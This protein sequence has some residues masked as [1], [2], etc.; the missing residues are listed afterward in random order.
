MKK[1]NPLF[2]IILIS[3]LISFYQ[4]SLVGQKFNKYGINYNFAQTF[5]WGLTAQQWVEDTKISL[6]NFS[7]KDIQKDYSSPV[8]PPVLILAKKIEQPIVLDKINLNSVESVDVVTP[9]LPEVASPTIVDSKCKEKCTILTIGDSIMGDVYY[10]LN[11]Q[12]KKYHPDWKIVN[13]HKVSSGLSNSTY[14]NWPKVTQKLVNEVKPDYVIIL[15]GMNDAQAITDESKGIQFNTQEWTRVYKERTQSMF[16]IMNSK[17][18][19]IWIELPNV[20]ADSFD[21]R[22]K[23]VREIH[24]SITQNSYLSVQEIIGDNHSVNFN[25]FRQADG[26]HLNAIGADTIAEYIY[27]H[28]LN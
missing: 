21:K 10:S 14:Y 12:L 2:A 28:R 7:F 1:I 8:S 22:L 17:S 24:K 27:T 4:V 5:S 13:A 26:I 23:Q 16:N 18:N 15:I 20:K 11:R 6:K 3:F 25:K 19:S 9:S